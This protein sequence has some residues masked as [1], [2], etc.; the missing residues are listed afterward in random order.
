MK[1]VNTLKP[2]QLNAIRMLATGAPAYQVAEKLEITTMTLWR[3]QRLPE[4]ERTLQSI[5]HSGLDELAKKMNIAALTAVE[6]LQEILCDM[7]LPAAT[8]IRAAV[9]AL[10]AMPSVNGALEKSLQHRVADF[11]PRNRFAGPTFTHDSDGRPCSARTVGADQLPD[12]VE[13]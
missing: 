5:A 3:W 7:R 9:G 1:P 6:V 11:D 12:V 2:K 10:R 4:F 8:K 13:V